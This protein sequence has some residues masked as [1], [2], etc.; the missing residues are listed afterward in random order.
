MKLLSKNE[1][2][3]II[4]DICKKF[5]TDGIKHL[6]VVGHFNVYTPMYFFTVREKFPD[7]PFIFMTE[8]FGNSKYHDDILGPTMQRV[9]YH[10]DYDGLYGIVLQGMNDA[11]I[12]ADFGGKISSPSFSIYASRP[13]LSKDMRE[14]FDRAL[15]YMQQ[16]LHYDLPETIYLPINEFFAH[17]YNHFP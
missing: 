17:T 13:N 9:Q 3:D 5:H 12:H 8:L 15:L 2:V 14:D 11:H 6:S 7:S 4:K 16:Q 1:R 10:G